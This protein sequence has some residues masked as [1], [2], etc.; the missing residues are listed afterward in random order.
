MDH[1]EGP[2]PALSARGQAA[3]KYNGARIVAHSRSDQK[4]AE[5]A[6]LVKLI[7]ASRALQPAWWLLYKQERAER[8]ARQRRGGAR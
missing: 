2:A 4:S 1:R 8:E 3:D 5:R 6:M 7:G